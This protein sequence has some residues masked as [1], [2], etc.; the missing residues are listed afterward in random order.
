MLCPSSAPNSPLGSS[1]ASNCSAT[2][3]EAVPS[4]SGGG[5]GINLAPVFIGIAAAGVL[6]LLLVAWTCWHRAW[7]S[8]RTANAVRTY[9]RLDL[10]RLTAENESAQRFVLFVE[11]LE[12]SIGAQQLDVDVLCRAVNSHLSVH[13]EPSDSCWPHTRLRSSAPA[14]LSAAATGERVL[15]TYCN[16]LQAEGKTVELDASAYRLTERLSRPDGSVLA[17]ASTSVNAHAERDAL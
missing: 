12:R 10:G 2:L 11:I 17:S 13:L 6:L 1:V 15:A 16:L 4:S 7:L 5:G 3:P 9:L 8:H 14:V